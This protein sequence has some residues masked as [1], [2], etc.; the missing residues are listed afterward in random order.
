MYFWRGV[1]LCFQFCEKDHEANF[2]VAVLN[3]TDALLWC[4]SRTEMWTR[5]PAR[6]RWKEL[7]LGRIAKTNQTLL[8]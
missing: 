1:W 8:Q 4:V 6:L 3:K 7:P 5:R 2:E